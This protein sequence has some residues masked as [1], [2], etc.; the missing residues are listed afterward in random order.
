MTGFG[1]TLKT[2]QARSIGRNR[3]QN[4]ALLGSRRVS[5]LRQ[6]LPLAPSKTIS[7]R[8]AGFSTMAELNKVARKLNQR[9]RKTSGYAT[10]A[11]KLQASVAS[12]G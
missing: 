5:D 10:L 8:P 6:N 12:I 7:F 11:D 2:E 9:P 3:T 4:Q 1:P